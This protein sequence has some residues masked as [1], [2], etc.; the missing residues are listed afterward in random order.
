MYCG[1]ANYG[2]RCISDHYLQ[3][4]PTPSDL[5]IKLQQVKCL[6]CVVIIRLVGY[7]AEKFKACGITDLN[8]IV[9][10]SPPACVV[11]S[12]NSNIE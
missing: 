3:Y 9:F 10:C 4:I 12:V 1:N 7:I 6:C 2:K 11:R 5:F 8:R